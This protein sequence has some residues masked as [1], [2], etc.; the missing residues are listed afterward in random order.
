MTAFKKL[1]RVRVKFGVHRG[2]Y[3][4]IVDVGGGDG[5]YYGVKLDCEPNPMGFS[6]YELDIARPRPTFPLWQYE[7]NADPRGVYVPDIVAICPE[8]RGE[9]V[10]RAMAWEKDGRPIAAAIELD[11]MND[12]RDGKPCHKWH[13]SDWQPARDAVAAW[14]DAKRGT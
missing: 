4:T 7:G 13:Q 10:A 9:L 5:T 14:C 12:L 3:G 8:C 2:H 6:E 11:C 1:D